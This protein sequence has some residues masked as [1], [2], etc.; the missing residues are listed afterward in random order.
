MNMSK[1]LLPVALMLL[2]LIA[3]FAAW[4]WFDRPPPPPTLSGHTTLLPEPR[5]IG[6]VGLVDAED[7]PFTTE[8]F[9]G[10]WNLVFFG[11][12]HCPD[13]CPTT[14]ADL[15]ATLDRLAALPHPGDPPRV[16]FVSVDP[17][18]DRGEQLGRFVRYFNKDFVGLTGTPAALTEFTRRLGVVYMKVAGS[19]GGDGY[20][21]DHSA[22][23][24]LIDPEARLHAIMT[25]PHDPEALAGDLAEILSYHEALR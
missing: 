18:R 25:P 14:L 1:R 15:N 4:Q 10:H 2:A 8:D 24:L 12:T 17:E 13:V 16:V 11:Y 23:V 21:V 6:A 3:G 7:R 22:A 5:P 9:R 20:L 19:E